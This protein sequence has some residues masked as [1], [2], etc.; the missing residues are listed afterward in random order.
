VVADEQADRGGAHTAPRGTLRE[1]QAGG[2][3]AW[4][5]RD[6]VGEASVAA[7][8]QTAPAAE[9]VRSV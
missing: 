1:E 8:A 9:E 2:D 5:A 6:P 7:A 4:A 3:G